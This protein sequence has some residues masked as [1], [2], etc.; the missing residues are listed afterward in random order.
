MAR[1]SADRRSPTTLSGAER[2]LVAVALN[3]PLCGIH[4]S[5]LAA[6][7]GL[8]PAAAAPLIAALAGDGF[9]VDSPLLDIDADGQ[10]SWTVGRFSEIRDAG[11]EPLPPPPEPPHDGPL[12]DWLHAGF[13]NHPD[14]GALWLPDDGDYVALR[15]LAEPKAGPRQRDWA[16]RH[17]DTEVLIR[18]RAVVDDATAASIDYEISVRAEPVP[19]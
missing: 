8:E 14:P 2:R 9:L 5:A 10:R 15:L 1:I 16:L 17:L 12:P 4:A 18:A 6:D 11:I 3:Y 13:W 19:A 7:A